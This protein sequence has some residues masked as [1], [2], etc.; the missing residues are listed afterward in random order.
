MSKKVILDFLSAHELPFEVFNHPPLYTC[1]DAATLAPAMPGAMTKNLFLQYKDS[2][3]LEQKVSLNGQRYLLVTVPDHMRVDLKALGTEL[4]TGKLSFAPPEVLLE[5]L[6]LT[7][8]AVSLLGLKFDLRRWVTPIIDCEI[9]E[10]ELIQCHPM[11]NTAT[12]VI[13]K[14]ALA[15]FFELTG[16]TPQ[17]L[18]IPRRLPA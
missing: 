16:H 5:L 14:A 15:K 12:C 2:A 9:W 18:N 10:S 7:P 6:Q 13:P 17:V 1:E 4:K 8:G 3:P 11:E